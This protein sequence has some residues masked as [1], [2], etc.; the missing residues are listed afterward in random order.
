[1]KKQQLTKAVTQTRI[2]VDKVLGHSVRVYDAGPKEFDRYTIIIYTPGVRNKWDMY[3]MSE[4]ALGFNQYL[5]SDTDFQAWPGT[6]RT[7]GR[8]VPFQVLSSP[9]QRAIERRIKETKCQ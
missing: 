4:N 1:M 6:L 8:R 7:L 5:G 9:L 3:G 2:G